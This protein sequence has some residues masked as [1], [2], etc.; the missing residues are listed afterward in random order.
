MQDLLTMT[1]D[2]A[3]YSE[4]NVGSFERWG[5]IAAGSL[6][7]AYAFSKRSPGAAW[8]AAAGA[9]L[10]HRGVTGHCYVYQGLGVNRAHHEDDTRASLGGSR[11]SHVHESV[12]IERSVDELYRFWRRFDNLPRFM[13]NLVRVVDLGDGRSH[14]VAKGP[15]GATVEW[16]AELIND[17]A[18]KLIS[19]RSLPGS[20]VVTAGSVKFKPIRGGRSTELEVKLQY[21][22]P[23]G[24]AGAMVAWLLGSEP[25]Q[26][27]REDLRRLKQI[28]EAGESA[29]AVTGSPTR[30]G[31]RP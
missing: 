6:L 12:R 15:A 20:D 21:E 2:S 4:R 9:P 1:E 14:W 28:F 24:R 19:W 10:L 27:I 5:S 11:G 18:D 29:T 13:N 7:L 23:A 31:A 30:E 22:P 17:I 26:T 25:S 16:D 8:L 3:R